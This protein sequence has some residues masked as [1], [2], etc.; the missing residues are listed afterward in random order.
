MEFRLRHRDGSYRWFLTQASLEFDDQGKAVRIRGSNV[1]VTER[2]VAEE[3]LREAERLLCRIG[4]AGRH[5]PHGRRSGPRNQQPPG[6]HQELF[7]LIKNAVPKDH[8]DFDMV[9]RIEREIDRIARIVRQMYQ[10]Y[11]PRVE[12]LIDI[13][14]GEIVRNVLEML[15]PLRRDMGSPWKSGPFRPR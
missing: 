7:R 14:V 2:K 12:K 9:E 13:P 10:I 11:S 5:R 8:P 4:E 3:R 15:E 1:D 6:R